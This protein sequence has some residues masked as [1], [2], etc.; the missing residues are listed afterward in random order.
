MGGTAFAGPVGIVAEGA[1]LV[2]EGVATYKILDGVRRAKAA[3]ELGLEAIEAQILTGNK[4]VETARVPIT[5]LLS[6]KNVIDLT[7]QDAMNRWL[8]I[9]KG[10]RAGDRFPPVKIEPGTIGTPI[11]DVP[12]LFR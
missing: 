2:A 9:L 8:T 5:N 12:F 4:V 3:A 11:S 10:M 7:R 6:P 1:V